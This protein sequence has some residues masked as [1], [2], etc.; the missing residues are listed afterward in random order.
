MAQPTLKAALLDLPAMAG[1]FD[2]PRTGTSLTRE[3]MRL[4]ALA[5]LAASVLGAGFLIAT[6]DRLNGRFDRRRGTDF[7]SVYSTDG[8]VL[9]GE[10]TMPFVPARQF[11][12][13]QPIFGQATQFYSWH[14]PPFLLVIAA[15]LAAIPNW[16]ALI[17]WQGVTIIFFTCCPCARSSPPP[18]PCHK[19]KR[20][21][22]GSCSWSRSLSLLCS[23]APSR[24]TTA[25]SLPRW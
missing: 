18:A 20:K 2:I 11:A 6:S 4:V 23:P 13:E 8:Y 9:D 15:L 3:W 1:F 5:L 16:L 22:I 17:L 21:L 14:Y 19:V 12:R 25:F 24:H 10:P 7:S